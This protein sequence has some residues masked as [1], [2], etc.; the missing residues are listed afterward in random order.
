MEQVNCPTL[1]ERCRALAR[2]TESVSGSLWIAGVMVPPSFAV[3]RSLN[4]RIP[5]RAC[6]THLT[7]AKMHYATVQIYADTVQIAVQACSISG[8][9]TGADKATGSRRVG[10]V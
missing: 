9:I 2:T 8:L 4:L 6:K 3:V 7:P 10:N 5:V 1:I